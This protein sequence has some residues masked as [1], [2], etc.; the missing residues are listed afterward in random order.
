MM[1]ARAW[2]LS[3]LLAGAGLPLQVAA[4][5]AY[6]AKPIRIVV[7]YPPGGANDVISRII[8]EGLT[9]ALRQQTNIDNR[10]GAGGII[11]SQLVA[12][13][14]ADGHT[15]LFT[16][17]AHAINPAIYKSIPYDS[18]ASFELLTQVAE[19]SFVLLVHPAIPAQ[20]VKELVALAK[21]RPGQLIF[22]SAGIG[23]ATHLAGELF[24]LQTGTDLVHVPYKGGG[25][26]LIDL[27]SGQVSMYFGTIAAGLQYVN[28]R[29]V[30]PL[31]VTAKTRSAI[32]PGVPTVAESGYPDY[33]VTA[34]WLMMAPKGTSS[35][36]VSTLNQ[37][38]VRVLR[39]REPREV[40]QR[41][42]IDVVGSSP[43]QATT[44]LQAEIAKWRDVVRR[45]NISVQ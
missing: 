43:Q 18:V 26:A 5:S 2:M 29:R 9:K 38:I 8:G 30:K 15:L 37:E 42:G 39:A 34:W 19:G 17:A 33:D 40:L 35:A 10:G 13:S 22:A 4:Q 36:V 24:K 44:F 23:N 20:S 25:P 12:E 6:P 45:G 27:L 31:A 41:Q 3:L 21:R 16:S 32:L 11:G 1:A 7:P 14:P 28:A